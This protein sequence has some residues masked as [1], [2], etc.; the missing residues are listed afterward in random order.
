[1]STSGLRLRSATL[2]VLL[3]LI[4]WKDSSFGKQTI[5]VDV[6]LI[7][8]DVTVLDHS[9]EIVNRLRKEDFS[10]DENG[11]P[12]SIQHFSTIETPYN[13]LVLIDRSGSVKQVRPLIRTAVDLF[14]QRLRPS[15]RVAIATFGHEVSLLMDWRSVSEVIPD[16]VNQVTFGD[17]THFYDSL[18]WSLKK[19]HSQP[20]RRGVI[21]ITDGVDDGVVKMRRSG[22]RL[23]VPINDD[24][25]LTRLAETFRRQ[26]VPYYFIAVGASNF[27]AI[28]QPRLSLLSDASGGNLVVPEKP[29]DLMPLFEKIATGLGRAYT[30]AYTPTRTQRDGTYRKINVVI[31]NPAL[32][33]QQSRNG[34][35]AR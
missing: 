1:M 22:G 12:Q 27:L 2:F 34:Y 21:V 4:V 6:P 5:T 28:G 30:L 29:D 14:A 23:V 25:K 3:S 20:N 26:G 8:V 11:E 10:I 32:T 24:H 17:P 31:R 35:Y 33:L 15:D 19:V 16:F 9:G 7:T 18:E 13:I